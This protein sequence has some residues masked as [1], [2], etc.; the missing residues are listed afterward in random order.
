MELRRALRGK[1]YVASYQYNYGATVYP[2]NQDLQL[3]ALPLIVMGALILLIGLLLAIGPQIASMLRETSIP[4][5]FRSLLLI[6]T[7][8]GGI[9]IY[10]SPLLIIILAILYGML[11][12]RR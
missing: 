11:L 5:P 6:G 1:K 3:I 7:R 4:E 8:V 9:E 10:T 12:L 2:S